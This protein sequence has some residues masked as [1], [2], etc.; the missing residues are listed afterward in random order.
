M[1][2]LSPTPTADLRI[3]RRS[4]EINQRSN[5]VTAAQVEKRRRALRKERK[6]QRYREGENRPPNRSILM[7]CDA[8]RLLH[9][10]YGA[11]L[12]DDDAGR[13]DVFVIVNMLIV[14]SDGLL[15]ARDWVRRRAP[16]YSDELERIADALIRN[17][18]RFKAA[19]L[20]RMLNLTLAER[21]RLRITT[22]RAVD[23]ITDVQM[24]AHRRKKNRLIQQAKRRANGAQSRADSFTRT[25]PWEGL[26]IS[27]R[28]FYRRMAKAVQERVAQ[29]R[30]H[31]KACSNAGDES[32][33]PRQPPKV[34]RSES[35]RIPEPMGSFRSPAPS[36]VLS[37]D[38]PAGG[39][40]TRAAITLRVGTD[41]C[42]PR[43]AAA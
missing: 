28:T 12:P 41:L 31:P 25:K 17:P 29:L 16:W 40:P 36:F 27:R 20:G 7:F 33:P 37:A 5:I 43:E 39:C 32:V 2:D 14:L 15:R 19:T 23:C 35:S 3:E 24:A 6:L 18:Y 34:A 38:S 8:D 11:V 42:Q 10:R 1:L 26:G 22:I 4:A 13:E 30:H 21:D 9:S